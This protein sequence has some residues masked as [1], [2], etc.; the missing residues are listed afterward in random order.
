MTSV[1][2]VDPGGTTGLAWADCVCFAGGRLDRRFGNLVS[3]MQVGGPAEEQVDEMLAL[4]QAV[5]VSVLVIESFQLRPGAKRGDVM[6]PVVVDA[7]LRYGL[8]KGMAG[9]RGMDVAVYYQTASQGKSVMTDG[10]LR[11]LGLWWPGEEHARDAARHLVTFVRRVRARK[12][13]LEGSG[14][15]GGRGGD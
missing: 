12:V 14:S 10:R 11:A 9:M 2:A 1:M 8:W 4:V 6:S 13:V 5:Q 3:H 15:G 7:M